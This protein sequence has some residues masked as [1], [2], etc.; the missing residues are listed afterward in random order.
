MKVLYCNYMETALNRAHHV[1]EAAG[2]NPTLEMRRIESMSREVWSLSQYILKIGIERNKDSLERE[3]RLVKQ[4]PQD[5]MIPKLISEGVNDD[6]YWVLMEKI[7]GEKLSTIWPALT[8]NEKR[9]SISTIS[10][11]LK[12]LHSYDF[13]PFLNYPTG[14]MGSIEFKKIEHNLEIIKVISEIDQGIIHD[15]EIIIQE[16]QSLLEGV[17]YKPIHGDLHFANLLWANNKIVAVLDF[18]YSSI[19][20]PDLELDAILRF[21]E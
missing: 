12:K 21:C 11:I 4:L 14:E 1:L 17:N 15:A 6:M 5:L 7:H 2:I 13:D 19:A 18:E 16:F 10:R 20:P 9:E 8:M 3:A